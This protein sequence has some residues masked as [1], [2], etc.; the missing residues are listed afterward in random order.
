L[1]NKTIKKKCN[2]IKDQKKKDSIQ[3][4]KIKIKLPIMVLIQ[5]ID[6]LLYIYVF[7]NF[8]YFNTIDIY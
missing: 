5:E 3:S 4:K 7:F 6:E 8:Y 1:K 2:K